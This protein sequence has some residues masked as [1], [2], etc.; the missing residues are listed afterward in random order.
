MTVGEKVG[1]S[2]AWTTA[3]PTGE[4]GAM[5]STASCARRDLPEQS[6]KERL[7]LRAYLRLGPE[8]G[9]SLDQLCGPHERVVGDAGHRRVARAAQYAQ[10]ERSGHLLRDRRQVDRPAVFELD[11]LAASLVDR[12][13]A[14]NGVGMRL[15]QPLEA[16]AGAGLLVG[17]RRE[18]Q[19]AARPEALARERRDRNRVR[20]DLALHVESAAAP[21]HSVAQLA[22][23]RRHRPFGRVREHDV[24]VAEEEERGAV[25]T[26]DPRDEIRTLRRP[27]DQL[28]LDAVGGEVVAQEL[29]RRGLVAGRVRRV[30]ADQ[31]LEEVGDLFAQCRLCCRAH[32]R[33]P[34][35]RTYLRSSTPG[36]RYSR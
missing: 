23:E 18:D 26:R 17:G 19:I 20:R 24:R 36:A 6:R 1:A 10:P 16:E 30:D 29:R 32:R 34:T 35:T 5:R 11:P 13:V 8:R 21:D 7:D 28:A 15:A 25:P 9:D 2:N 12:E 4:S 31:P 3:A 14:P 27:R 33:S 22:R